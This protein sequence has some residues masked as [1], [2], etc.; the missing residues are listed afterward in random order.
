MIAVEELEEMLALMLLVV[1]VGGKG[2]YVGSWRRH[3]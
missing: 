1:G 3:I 2:S